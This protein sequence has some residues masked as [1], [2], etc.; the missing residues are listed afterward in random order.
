MRHLVAALLGLSLAAL[1]GCSST[2][3]APTAFAPAGAWHTSAGTIGLTALHGWTFDSLAEQRDR[4]RGDGVLMEVVVEGPASG[5][6][7]RVERLLVEASF[8]DG[9]VEGD[10]MRLKFRTTEE[11]P[12]RIEIP[13]TYYFVGW[14]ESNEGG[15]PTS[16]AAF[17]FGHAPEW[18]TR[19]GLVE[20]DDTRDRDL[21]PNLTE[22]E[23]RFGFYTF[24]MS[25]AMALSNN[26]LCQRLLLRI[27]KQPSWWS[28]LTNR[29]VSVGIQ[30]TPDDSDQPV[31][32]RLGNQ[33]FD[34]VR[35]PMQII[36]NDKPAVFLDVYAAPIRGPLGVTNGIVLIE[37]R[38]P[39]DPDRRATLR[40]AGTR[41]IELDEGDLPPSTIVG[42]G[43]D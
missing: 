2:P 24:T 14:A 3:P 1:A 26:E 42:W 39:T 20:S 43:V 5:D 17:N 21:A 28:V 41:A 36:V 19:A 11:A 25:A 35:T 13:L 37:A 16:K 31:T 30:P 6:Q 38:H 4:R 27:A 34:G 23:R 7:Q 15:V 33:M 18:G 29:G 12:R 40:L 32:I 8:L 9:I 10:S 22:D